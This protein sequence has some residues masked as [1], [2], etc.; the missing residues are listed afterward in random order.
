M[1]TKKKNGTIEVYDEAGN[2]LEIY[3]KVETDTTLTKSNVAADGYEV[4]VKFK[5]A[6]NSLQELSE[7]LDEDKSTLQEMDQTLLSKINETKQTL[8]NEIDE[9]VTSLNDYKTDTETK[10]S[11]VN[12]SKSNILITSSF[13]FDLATSSSPVV[14]NTDYSKSFSIAKD[15]YTPLGIVSYQLLNSYSTRFFITTNK[16]SGN[17]YYIQYRA[18]DSAFSSTELKIT[19]T[20]LYVKS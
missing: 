18:N 8:Q 2:K 9:C 7:K 19:V 1:T 17:T 3:P 16:I 14:N 20:I 13:T 12:A 5:E 15:G 4:G 6:E 11:Q 10:I